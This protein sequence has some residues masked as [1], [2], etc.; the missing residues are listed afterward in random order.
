M[1]IYDPAKRHARSI[2]RSAVR[3]GTLPPANAQRCAECGATWGP[4]A[5]RHE[6]HHL[7]GYDRP[8]DVVC[9]CARCHVRHESRSRDDR[10]RFAAKGAYDALTAAERETYRVG[11]GCVPQTRSKLGV[12]GY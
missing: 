12:L 1:R 7:H 2:V 9:M 8:R 10:G 6:Y 3:N 11:G 4:G 5:S